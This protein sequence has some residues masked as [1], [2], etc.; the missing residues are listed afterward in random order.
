MGANA[1][2]C[3]LASTSSALPMRYLKETILS[4]RSLL[5]SVKATVTS[6]LLDTAIFFFKQ[7]EL[8]LH[9]VYDNRAS[10]LFYILQKRKLK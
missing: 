10:I 6:I 5:P 3:L 9:I 7:N 2:G 8:I 1:L 4:L